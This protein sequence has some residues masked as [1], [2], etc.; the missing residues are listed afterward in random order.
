MSDGSQSRTAGVT[1]ARTE[2][3]PINLPATPEQ[4]AAGYFHRYCVVRLTTSEG[5][6]GH[7]FAA[8]IDRTVWPTIIAAT[9]GSAVT[10]IDGMLRRG[11]DRGAGAEHAA[12]DALGKTLG[13]PVHALLGG[14]RMRELKGYVTVVWPGDPSQAHISHAETVDAVLAYQA[15]GFEGLKIRCWRDLGENARLCE[16]ILAATGPDFTL[17]VDRTAHVSGSTWS[18]EE[19]LAEARELQDI[20]VRWLEEPL[21]RYDL[22]GQARLADELEMQIVGGEGYTSPAEFAAALAAGSFDVIQPDASIANG[23]L[24]TV[25]V[26]A[27][28]EA[29]E[30]P[31]CLHGTGGLRLPGWLQAAALIGPEWQELAIIPPGLQPDEAWSLNRSVLR[32][33]PWRIDRGRITVPSGPGLGLD[34]DDDAL[35]RYR[36]G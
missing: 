36:I 9:E 14:A 3:F 25:R 19:A 33:D 21:D 11:L 20:G 31:V 26:A 8:S 16:A 17:M 13:E 4:V 12:W 2:I 27:M 28:A 32:N 22:Q 1:I 5:M 18:Y 24:P 7:S 15:A 10:D 34:V 23:I 30:V 35:D 6:R 29:L